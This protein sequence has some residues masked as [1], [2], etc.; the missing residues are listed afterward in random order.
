MVLVPKAPDPH[1]GR[2]FHGTTKVVM[3]E[4]SQTVAAGARVCNPQ[5]YST[6]RWCKPLVMRYQ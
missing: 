6:T 2:T 3:L 4:T 5:Q 1:R